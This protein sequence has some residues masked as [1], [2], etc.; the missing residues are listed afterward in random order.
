MTGPDPRD[1]RSGIASITGGD[2]RATREFRANLAVFARRQDDPEVRRMVA[3][4]LAGRR[5]VGDVLRS[6]AFTSVGRRHFENLQA[7]IAAM[8]PEQRAEAFDIDRPRTP[9]RDLVGL[10]DA[11]DT[12][13]WVPEDVEPEEDAV[14]APRRPETNGR[15]D[16]G[17]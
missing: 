13:G 12:S 17:R 4:V 5:P 8:T 3:E 10:R 15:D 1:V 16:S 14:A 11:D 6:E 2:V 7:G 9:Q